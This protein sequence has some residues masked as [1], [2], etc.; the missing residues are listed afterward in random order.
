MSNLSIFLVNEGQVLLID[1][2][3]QIVYLSNR[4]CLLEFDCVFMVLEIDIFR[5]KENKAK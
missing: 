2:S 4:N 3:L 1:L 5:W